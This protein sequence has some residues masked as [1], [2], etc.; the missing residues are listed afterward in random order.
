MLK[1]VHR[2]NQ[3]AHISL[4]LLII[5][6]STRQKQTEAPLVFLARLPAKS[7]FSF[8]F[9]DR[10]AFPATR[11]SVSARPVRGCLVLPTESR[12]TFFPEI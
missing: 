7:L 2:M 11:W 10:L 6:K 1:F 12:K 8:R 3:T 5:S 9:L 4:Q